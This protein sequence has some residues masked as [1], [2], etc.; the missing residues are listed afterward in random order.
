MLPLKIDEFQLYPIEKTLSSSSA[1]PGKSGMYAWYLNFSKFST[2]S[3]K[4]DFEKNIIKLDELLTKDTLTGSVKSFFK[5]FNVDLN[6]ER[7]WLDQFT[8]TTTG[9][10][11]TV[12]EK[13]N[14]LTL[15]QCQDIFNYLSQF[16]MLVSPLYV[17]IAKS[18]QTR[19]DGHKRAFY[20]IKKMQA[21]GEDPDVIYEEAE[22][23]FG[24][25][26]AIRGFNWEHLIFACA[27]MPVDRHTIQSQEFLINR[28]YSP[29]LG[30]K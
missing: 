17:G 29:I 14:T 22:K 3:S 1:I 18:L 21:D 13:L 2:I 7:I 9:K 15:S 30:R 16:S 23:S 19:F 26:A 12:G 6:E 5:R 4:D 28:L 27:E 10:V 11:I 20:E 25:R 8:T 24:G